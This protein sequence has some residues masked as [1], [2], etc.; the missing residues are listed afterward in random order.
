MCWN[1]RSTDAQRHLD[2]PIEDIILKLNGTGFPDHTLLC[3]LEANGKVILHLESANPKLKYIMAYGTVSSFV[4]AF[5][6]ATIDQLIDY[7]IV[8]GMVTWSDL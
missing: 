7:F 5:S 3:D 1:V 2:I 4:T 8:V 6:N